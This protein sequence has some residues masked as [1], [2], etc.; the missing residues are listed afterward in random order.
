[1]PHSIVRTSKKSASKFVDAGMND[2]C[3]SSA[4]S[5]NTIPSTEDAALA[6]DLAS[7]SEH[8]S[9]DI[10]TDGDSSDCTAISSSVSTPSQCQNPDDYW[11]LRVAKALSGN[12]FVVSNTFVDLMPT[13]EQEEEDN[14]MRPRSISD[15]TGLQ[16]LHANGITHMDFTC[17]R[18]NNE[19]KASVESKAALAPR[20]SEAGSCMPVWCSLHES[21][22]CG[23]RIVPCVS[24]AEIDDGMAAGCCHQLWCWVQQVGG[25][26]FIVPIT[27]FTESGDAAKPPSEAELACA[28]LPPAEGSHVPEWNSG[29]CWP[30]NRLPTTLTLSNLPAELTTDCLLEVLDKFGFSGFYD[31]VFL[32]MTERQATVNLIRHEYGLTLAA[33]MHQFKRWGDGIVSDP[34]KV[35]WSLPLQGFSSLV[36]HFQKHPLNASGTPEHLL[37]QVFSK[38]WPVSFPDVKSLWHP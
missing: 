27:D 36:A 19:L 37:P 12:K 9:N 11:P 1:M 7:C 17:L 6:D 15:W 3:S 22:E 29:P 24:Q 31:F 30:F 4:H 23:F 25:E 14:E 16:N 38:G 21:N 2:V 18:N 28:P 8:D 35:S 33:T 34:C 10:S 20:H 32:S 26:K 5:K 13:A